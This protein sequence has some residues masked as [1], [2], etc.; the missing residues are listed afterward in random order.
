M[1]TPKKV[2]SDVEYKL[3]SLIHPD[4]HDNYHRVF[5]DGSSA[6]FNVPEEWIEVFCADVTTRS[7]EGDFTLDA[8]RERVRSLL[9]R[10]YFPF[11]NTWYVS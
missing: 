3:W 2:S 9:S 7:K 5:S 8:L 11:L 4:R 6:H 10:Q 1:F